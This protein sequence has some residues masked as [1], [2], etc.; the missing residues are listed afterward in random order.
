MGSE[1]SCESSTETLITEEFLPCGYEE[2]KMVQN[3]RIHPYSAIGKLKFI[4]YNPSTK[5][6]KWNW[7]TGFL[8][9][10]EYVLTVA[11]L[12]KIRGS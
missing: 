12:C 2:R 5:Q 6:K 10:P 7:G 9:T 4:F 3:N 1:L 8:I 11:H